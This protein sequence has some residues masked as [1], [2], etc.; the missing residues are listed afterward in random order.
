MLDNII[1]NIIVKENEDDNFYNINITGS[2]I[3]VNMVLSSFNNISKYKALAISNLK[4][5]KYHGLKVV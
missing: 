2:E 4:Q 3:I 5:Y 1:W